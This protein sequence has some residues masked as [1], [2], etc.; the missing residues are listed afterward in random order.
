MTNSLSQSATDFVDSILRMRPAV[1]AFDC[2]GTLWSDDAGEAFFDW[3]LQQNLLSDEIVDWARARYA[4]Y[5]AGRVSEEAMCGE[6]VTMH[7]G[8]G[9]PEISR[10]A[11]RFFD[12]Y[13]AENIFPEMQTLVQELSRQGC[14]VWAVSS[15]NEWIIRAAMRHFQLPES[16]VIASCARVV[17]G[18]VTGQLIQV[19]SGEGK[20]RAIQ[21]TIGKAPD[22]AFGNSIWDAAMLGIARVAV[23]VNP[24]P[25]LEKLATKRNWRIYRPIS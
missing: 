6:M 3:E 5:R 10:M 16:R 1:A 11:A 21:Q 2:D 19:P 14:D 24:T 8:L 18:Q 25:E 7:R 15:T 23:A 4:A 13:F 17:N 20:C 9:E 12:E 22:A